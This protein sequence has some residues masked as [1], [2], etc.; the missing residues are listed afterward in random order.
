MRIYPAIDIRNGKCVITDPISNTDTVY[1]DDP[2]SVAEKWVSG[3]ARH[4][5][6]VDLDGAVRGCSYNTNIIREIIK[7]SDVFIQTGGGVRSMRGIERRIDA[8]VSG[9]VIATAAV[10]TPELVKEAVKNYGDKIVVA[11]D[12][13]NGRTAIQ[14]WQEI[15]TQSVVSLF[16]KMIEYGVKNFIYTDVSRNVSLQGPEVE[17]ISQ[18]VKMPDINVIASGGI[19]SMLDLE[20]LEAIGV[21]GVI[22]SKA[23][24]QGTLN[25]GEVVARFEKSDLK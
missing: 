23:L 4:L 17:F 7:D 8:G 15:S 19:A 5:H 14:G 18:L 25:I 22:L 6:I 10:T 20:S 13:V 12:A 1:A 16:R 3:G 21:S 2:V 11:I 24:Y 9:V